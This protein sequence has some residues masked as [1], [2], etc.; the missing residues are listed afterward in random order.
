MRFD[1]K[2]TVKNS[3]RAKALNKLSQLPTESLSEGRLR[4]LS[5][6]LPV[7]RTHKE[8]KLYSIP[9]TLN[10]WEILLS[11]CQSTPQT[12]SQARDLLNDVVSSYFVE[13][14]RQRV[15]EVLDSMFKLEDLKH[16]NE[17]LTFE[18]TKFLLRVC[19]KF[20][21]LTRL[22]GPLIDQYMDNISQLFGETSSAAISLIGFINAFICEGNAI[23]LSFLAWLRLSQALKRGGLLQTPGISNEFTDEV[24]VRYYD[25]GNEVSAPLFLDLLAQFQ[26]S[27]ASSIISVPKNGQSLLSELLLEAQLQLF[28]MHQN[29][30]TTPENLKLFLSGIS[31]HTNLIIDMCT[32]ALEYCSDVNMLDL[33]SE[34]RALNSFEAQAHFIEFLCL[35]PFIDAVDGQLFTRFGVVVS[36]AIDRFL[37]SDAVTS[38]LVRS[39]VAA[40]SLM[41]FYSEEF[42]LAFL[43]AFPMLVSSPHVET[44]DVA[45]VSK[46]FALGLKPLNEDAVVS[47]VYTINN[48]LTVYEDGAPVQPLRERHLTSNSLP[49]HQHSLLR[50][51]RA[52]TSDTMQVIDNINHDMV[53]TNGKS[54]DSPNEDMATYHRFLFENCVTAVVVIASH[55]NDQ[56]I[57]ALTVT[58]LTQKVFVFSD[59]LDETILKLLPLLAAHTTTTEL[60]LLLT[61]YKLAYLQAGKRNK[62]RLQN[63]IVLARVS[64]SRE[65]LEKRFLSDMYI[66]MLRDLLDLIA[67]CGEGE[68]SDHHRADTEITQFAEQIAIYLSPLAALMPK[69]GFPPLNLTSDEATTISFRNIWFNMVVH[70]FHYDSEIVKKHYS[71][72]VVIAYNT[73]PLASD[74]PPT[75][76]EVSLEM[77][78]I[79]RRSSSSSNIKQQKHAI[80]QFLQSSSVQNRNLSTSKIMFLASTLLLEMLRCDAGDCSQ[81]LHYFCDPSVVRSSVDKAVGDINIS[82]IEKYTFFVQ[83]GNYRLA[84]SQAVAKQLNNLLLRLPDRNPYAQA[85]AF[86][87]CETFIKK[88]PSSLCHHHSLYTLLDLLT[89]L[90]DSVTD[91][92]IN[93]FE[94]HYEFL[95]KHSKNKI[96]LP[97]SESWR[98]QTLTTLYN[99]SKHWLKIILAKCNQD[100]KILLQSYVSDVTYSDRLDDIEYGVS[101]AMEMA[102]TIT[103]GDRELSKLTYTG[104]QKPNT[105]AKFISQHSWRSKSLVDTAIVSSPE[106][107]T[108]K[109]DIAVREMRR[110]LKSGEPVIFEHVVSFLDSTSALL[111]LDKCAAGSLISDIVYIPFEVFTSPALK[112]ATNVWLTIT[113]ERRDLA[114][115]LLVAVGFR[116]M[117]SIDERK[118]LFSRKHDLVR[119]ENQPMLYSPY[120]KKAINRTAH[121]ASQSL[122]PH[123]YIIQFFASH[124]EGTMFQSKSLLKMFTQWGIYGLKHLKYASLHPFAR[125]LR[126]ELLNFAVL[127]LTV[128]YKQ[129]TRYVASL[130][131]AIID[132]A[133]SWFVKPRSWPFGSNQL[134]IKADL[135]TTIQLKNELDA[136]SSLMTRYSAAE[137]KLLQYFLMSE[138]MYIETWLA[139]MVKLKESDFEEPEADLI[140]VAFDKNPALAVGFLQRF[141]GKRQE[142][143]LTD[144]VVK[145]PLLCI[146]VPELLELYLTDKA[147][148][149]QL[150][151][152]YVSY[153]CSV[154]PL[155]SINLFLSSWNRNTF[156]LQ[157]SVFSLESHPV[158]VTFFYVPQIVQ[159]LRFDH[160]GYVEKLILDTAKTSVLFA[161]QIV[162]NMLANSYKDDEGLEEDELKPTLDRVRN[163]M[164]STFDDKEREFYEREFGFFNEVTSISGKLKPYIKKSKA[165]KKQKIDEE[166]QKIQ[167]KPDVYLPS[168]PDGVVIDIDRKSGKPLQSHAKAP[169]MATFK[170]KKRVED[171]ETGKEKEIEKW[172]A[173]IFKVGDDCRQDVLALQLI[174]MFRTIWSNIALDVYVYPYRVTATAA[175]C[176]VIDVLPNSISRDMLG[177][178]AVNGLYEYF[179]T[180]FGDEGT[181][182]FQNA[183]NNFVKSLAGYSVISYLLQFKDRHNGNIMYDDQGHCLHIDFGF[184]F[185]I[186]PGGVKFEAVPFKLTKEMV[187]VMGGSP[188]T[189]AYRDFEELCVKAYLGARPHMNAIIECVIPMLQSGLPCFKGLKTI[190]HLR[191]R[192]QP[193]K[194]EHEAA[195]F[196]RTLIKKSYESLFTV[197]YDEFQKLTNG[198]PY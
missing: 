33:S 138:I 30:A 100:T 193:N 59:E 79:L 16:P 134:K 44:Q 80:S 125:M 29:S 149:S 121:D 128:N 158:N 164:I 160:S 124:F 159:C 93:R 113:K 39:T 196:M 53:M 184:I 78:T 171:S 130:C 19:T 156:V 72:L 170:I 176:G 168:N 174:S 120:D 189:Q 3:V 90:F 135:A 55:Y 7:F 62:E 71:S 56:S 61:F 23:E 137:F 12:L 180:K 111:L 172:Q 57:T 133:L 10:E 144:L 101:F 94:P 107:I 105:I 17:I 118:G 108:H 198:I 9:L 165:E 122:Q 143:I 14:P 148:Q 194:T 34:T 86:Q 41:N 36:D 81:V 37:L 25:S 32:F 146:G 195:L 110:A 31:N 127:L 85:A 8:A 147:S 42:S 26:V 173:A 91:C 45:H 182:E 46:T 38:R 49:P 1:V 141:P 54:H 64:M 5:Q 75:K 102:G 47:T 11:L 84:D 73:P 167:V 162:W 20:P 89:T 15:S 145:N 177:R 22:C 169:F 74:F 175:G 60:N 97:D 106:D 51:G 197:G 58:I 83:S 13:S 192:F 185:D 88:I 43:K 40:A 65:L 99:Y 21:A 131:Q 178:E 48:F 115:I 76:R 27:L 52:V 95:L 87:T 82:I 6:D 152:H 140:K 116:W 109:I 157:Y 183:R 70:G 2:R 139:P 119:E 4:H 179:I 67:A 153:W 66:M 98:K 188:D 24:L 166:M 96:L 136:V 154:S 129:N 63:C 150:D 142:E 132:G 126:N 117:K 112:L 161:H 92:E 186:V 18:L 103:V 77:N 114:N 187:K 190:K 123:H 151:L 191:N 181:I 35:V 68:K 50:K 104:R 69:P 155:K 163:R 28:E